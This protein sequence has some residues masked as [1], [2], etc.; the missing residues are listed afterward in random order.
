MPPKPTPLQ[1][2]HE[3]RAFNLAVMSDLE[4]ALFILIFGAIGACIAS[5]TA[6]AFIFGNRMAVIET[7]R[8]A[9]DKR[10]DTLIDSIGKRAAA[11]VHRDDDKHGIDK[12]LDK[13]LHNHFLSPD[14]WGEIKTACDKFLES[15]EIA[16]DLKI[17]Y[18]LLAAVC[19]DKMAPFKE[20]W[21]TKIP[22][23]NNAK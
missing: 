10:I 15:K 11:S 23:P 6:F 7:W 18:I 16:S 21:K 22:N 2:S 1:F 9:S 14:E 17:G 5:G 3:R 8:E 13:Y 12:Y 4:I 19:E 20:Y